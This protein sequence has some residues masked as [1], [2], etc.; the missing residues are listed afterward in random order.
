MYVVLIFLLV[1]GLN[2]AQ[3]NFEYKYGTYGS[4]QANKIIHSTNGGYIILGDG[5]I[6]RID[7]TGEVNWA[8]SFYASGLDAVEKEN[9]Y[10]IIGTRG[11]CCN[12]KIWVSKVDTIG[13]FIW[14]KMFGVNYERDYGQSIAKGINGGVI[15]AGMSGTEATLGYSSFLIKLDDNDAVEWKK[16][17]EQTS[18]RSYMTQSIIKSSDNNYILATTVGGISDYDRDIALIK[19]SQSGTLVWTRKYPGLGDDYPQSVVELPDSGFVVVGFTTSF[20]AQSQDMLV[21]RI[22]KSGIPLWT[23]IIGKQASEQAFSVIF[24]PDENLY[25]AGTTTSFSTRSATIIK[26]NLSG[27]IIWSKIYGGGNGEN[28]RSVINTNDNYI[29]TV[30]Y[31]N[32]LIPVQNKMYVLKTDDSGIGECTGTEI[33][34]NIQNV[35]LSHGNMNLTLV[36]YGNEFPST[37]YE[38]E[39]SI[40]KFDSCQIQ[41][42]I[43]V[44]LVSFTANCN[45]SLINISWSTASEINNHG[46]EIERSTNKNDWIKIGFKEGRGTTTEQQNYSYIDDVNG[47]NVPKLFYRLKQIDFDGSYEYSDVVEVTL[48]PIKFSLSQNYPNPFN[49]RTKISWQSP[50]GSHQTLK[51]YDVLGRE[52]ATLVNEYRDA[53]SYEVEFDASQLAS[54]VYYYQ[55][56]VGQF[57][58]T[59]KMILM[60]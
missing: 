41:I 53:G 2:I 5:I 34:Y 24:A 3:S 21:T 35:V 12:E 60:K 10:Y 49:P 26:M 9:Y 15:L 17:I 1:S 6:F 7:A 13:N 46:F 11:V 38:N 14:T 30:G 16:K 51:V 54:G 31:T 4:Q 36:N 8:K 55:L 56:K 57:V 45:Q 52:V 44:E 19:I 58:E 59:R 33:V 29:M 42:V 18:V 40:Y 22:N 39:Y 28:F 32:N 47:I 27:E 20:G 48:A 37:A 50:V 23:K 43:P 25:I